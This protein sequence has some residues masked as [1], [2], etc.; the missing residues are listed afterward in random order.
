MSFT[1]LTEKCRACPLLDTCDHKQM[2]AVAELSC[3]TSMHETKASNLTPMARSVVKVSID[4]HSELMYK[5]DY[6]KMIR[7]ALGFN[8]LQRSLMSKFGF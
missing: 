6:E 7:D 4:G 2:E 3:P 1:K 5:D 8:D